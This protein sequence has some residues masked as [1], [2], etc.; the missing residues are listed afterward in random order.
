MMQWYELYFSEGDVGDEAANR[1][2][3]STED[4][5]HRQSNHD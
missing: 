3:K 4:L 2:V 5:G 1:T